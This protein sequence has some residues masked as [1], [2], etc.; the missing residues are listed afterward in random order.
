MMLSAKKELFQNLTISW[1]IWANYLTIWNAA[2]CFKILPFSSLCLEVLLH[3]WPKIAAKM[4]LQI[5]PASQEKRNER[6]SLA[7][8][9]G[10]NNQIQY[11][12]PNGYLI[13]WISVPPKP[14]AKAF[15]IY[16]L[17]LQG[18][19]EHVTLGFFLFLCMESHIK[20]MKNSPVHTERDYEAEELQE[21]PFWKELIHK[22]NALHSVQ[23]L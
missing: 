9:E 10:Q 19:V 11:C 20:H 3:P 1:Q 7:S 8:P 6:A 5:F 4:K 21:E 18:G 17:T 22:S 12:D 2:F 13:L 14:T 23:A 15:Q 16:M